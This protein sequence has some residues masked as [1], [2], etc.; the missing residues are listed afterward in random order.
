MKLSSWTLVIGLGIPAGAHA[1][2]DHDHSDEG[3]KPPKPDVEQVLNPPAESA[4]EEIKRLFGEVERKLASVDILLTDAAAGDTTSLEEVE[5][6]GIADLLARSLE[7]GNQ[8]QTDIVRIL[9][10]A[11]QPGGG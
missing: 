7:L 4:Q 2:Q 5:A 11:E 1:L 8:L 10:L 9:E 6:A 3:R